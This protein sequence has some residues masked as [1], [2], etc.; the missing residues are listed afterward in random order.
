ML[1]NDTQDTWCFDY[2]RAVNAVFNAKLIDY[3]L[4]FLLFHRKLT[5]I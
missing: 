4:F 1:T 3:N 5:L 2:P